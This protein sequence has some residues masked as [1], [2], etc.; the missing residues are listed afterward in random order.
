VSELPWNERVTM[1]SINPDAASRHD[2]ARLAADLTEAK[3]ALKEK[4]A[5][6][7]EAR[8]KCEELAKERPISEELYD[9]V[10]EKNSRLEAALKAKDEALRMLHDPSCH[11]FGMRREVCKVCKALGAGGEGV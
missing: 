7:Q 6:T 8:S 3:A 4:E 2:V 10:V 9:F 11:P 5:E 1:L